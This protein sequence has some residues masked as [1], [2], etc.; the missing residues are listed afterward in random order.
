MNLLFSQ[1]DYTFA[2]E[3]H[4]L[5]NGRVREV[6]LQEPMN[7]TGFLCPSRRCLHITIVGV[8]SIKVIQIIVNQPIHAHY[9]KG[10]P[11]N[12]V[13]SSYPRIYLSKMTN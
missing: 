2:H 7:D 6:H 1:S 11:K 9:F 5:N 10:A 12:P 13:S 3:R 8:I 4:E